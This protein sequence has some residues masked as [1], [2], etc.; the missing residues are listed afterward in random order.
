MP[1]TVARDGEAALPEELQT[2]EKQVIKFFESQNMIIQ[3]DNVVAC[4]YIINPRR[5]GGA[6]PATVV[7]FV[8]RKHKLLR[9]AKKLKGTGVYLN[10]HLTKKN[11]DIAR[12][13]RILRKQNKIQATWTRNCKV[14]IRLNGTPEEAKVYAIR[15]LKELDQYG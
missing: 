8:N 1:S 9:Q 4:Y 15:E 5:N 2:L 11:A 13:A 7:R 10:E 3:S 6:K 12:H 14:M